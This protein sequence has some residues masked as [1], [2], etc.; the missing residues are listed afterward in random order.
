MLTVKVSG[1]RSTG[2]DLEWQRKAIQE[3][4]KRKVDEIGSLMRKSI[5]M[6]IRVNHP[7]K[8]PYYGITGK[9]QKWNYYHPGGTSGR[10]WKS[11]KADYSQEGARS[12]VSV[13]T[14][15]KHSIYVE[16]GSSPHDIFPKTKKVLRWIPQSGVIAY[17]K[18]V[19]HPGYMGDDIFNRAYIEWGMGAQV[20][21]L[22]AVE[23]AL[24]TQT[25]RKGPP[26]WLTKG[27]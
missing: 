24:T 13:S 16:R 5:S 17:R 6:E 12:E 19:R 4:T 21:I 7:K 2:Q 3:T 14:T 11:I 8:G 22:N 15:E 10:Y 9:P 1:V 27:A 23:R 25:S 18:K 20:R 26:D